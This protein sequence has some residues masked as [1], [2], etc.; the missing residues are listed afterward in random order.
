MAE[1]ALRLFVGIV[2]LLADAH[3]HECGRQVHE[4]GQVARLDVEIHDELRVCFH[5]HG[6]DGQRHGR[7]GVIEDD[8]LRRE[9]D[10][11]TSSIFSSGRRPDRAPQRP[12]AQRHLDGAGPAIAFVQ[13]EAAGVDEQD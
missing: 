10:V 8:A 3:R 12:R 2:V 11:E 13:H 1:P 9:G 4:E 7:I 5:T 6:D